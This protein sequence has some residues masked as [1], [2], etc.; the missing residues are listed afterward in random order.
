MK[1]A[2]WDAEVEQ[3][4]GEFMRLREQY[5]AVTN[6]LRE[7][8]DLEHEIRAELDAARGH[9]LSLRHAGEKF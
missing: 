7:Y 8:E 9:W 3:A 5:I 4:R 6:K 1:T 2:E